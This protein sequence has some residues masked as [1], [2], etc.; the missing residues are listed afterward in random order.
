MNKSRLKQPATRHGIQ[1][2]LREVPIAA[3]LVL[4]AVAALIDHVGAS[5]KKLLV[6][7]DALALLTVLYYFIL[8]PGWRPGSAAPARLMLRWLLFGVLAALLIGGVAVF[9]LIYTER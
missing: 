6:T 4:I 9:R 1:G 7:V 3:A 2:M 8:A 5:G